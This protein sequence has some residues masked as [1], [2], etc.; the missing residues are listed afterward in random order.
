M[1]TGSLFLCLFWCALAL[2]QL[3]SL[4]RESLEGPMFQS[5]GI[6]P[7]QPPQLQ[8]RFKSRGARFLLFRDSKEDKVSDYNETVAV[9]VGERL[10]LT[11]H[12]SSLGGEPLPKPLD[13]HGWLISLNFDARSF[14]GKE[15][16]RYAIVLLLKGA[17]LRFVQPDP[18]FDPKLP[19]TDPTY[20]RILKL[21][22]EASP[23]PMP[24]SF[25]AETPAGKAAPPFPV[26]ATKLV[27]E[28]KL[29]S[30]SSTDPAEIRWIAADTGGIAP[31]DH[32]ISSSKSEAGKREGV[33]SLSRPTNGFPPGKYRL[34][35][36]Q[37]DKLIYTED[38]DIR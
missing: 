36:R 3:K 12:H 2:A 37:A 32:V 11:E 6:K 27:F 15:T 28:W 38:F 31:Q 17:E 9:K 29:P 14:G 5:I 26:S 18:N 16:S 33:F 19:P 8:L 4:T 20:Q 24:H 10:T 35:L 13:E 23:T 21:V 30:G 22:A 25:F 34:E 1:K 7:G